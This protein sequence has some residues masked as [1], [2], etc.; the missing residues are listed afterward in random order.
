MT[1]A[2]LTPVALACVTLAAA[3]LL[4]AGCGREPMMPRVE[5][6]SGGGYPTY[7]DRTTGVEVILGTPDLGVGEQR[8]AFAVST[9]EGAVRYPALS[10]TARRG[11]TERRFEA[12]FAPF[13]LGS[14][15]LYAAPV[16]FDTAG[17]WRFE[18][19]IP[20]AQGD[21]LRARFPVEVRD[22]TSAPA[23]GAVAPASRNRTLADVG[24]IAE[25]TTSTQPD[26]ALYRTTIA[27]AIAAHRPTVIVFASPAFCTTAL[28]G[29][30]V[31]MLSELMPVYGAQVTFIHVDLYENPHE[32]KGDLS[33]ARR[34]PILDAWGLHGDEWT[35]V[36]GADGRI[37]A[38][39]ESFA[40]REEL[41]PAIRAVLGASFGAAR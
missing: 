38:R 4:L 3:A 29:P 31:E 8:V 25:L 35:F 12:Q 1:R 30:Q 21:P 18:V 22:R 7:R 9:H 2:R 11:D 34:T 20:T 28:C 39:F 33:R 23:V 15:G 27:D 36:I 37:A 32:I 26:P 24:T 17:E 6:P 41:E 19:T 40:P 10:V 13:P 16:D 5:A 14:R